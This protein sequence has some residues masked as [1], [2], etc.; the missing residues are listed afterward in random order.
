MTKNR[1][2]RA[3]SPKK[4]RPTPVRNHP[5]DA[6]LRRALLGWFRR[7]GRPLPWRGVSSPYPIWVSEVMLQQTQID[8]VIPYYHRFISR[9]PTVE[10]LAAAPL[11]RVLE[12]WSG[13]GYY[14]RARLLH[15]AAQEMVARF[16]G[17]FPDDYHAARS[18]PGVGDYT[19]RAVLSIAYHQAFAV[20]DG[21]VARVIARLQARK[22]NLHK[23][24]FRRAVEGVLKHLLPPHNPGEF[25][26]ALMQV[27]QLVCLP[28]GPRCDVCPLRRHCKSYRLGTPEHFPEPRP[29]RSAELYYLA[30]AVLR[31]RG[32]VALVRGLDQGLLGDLWNFPSA[33][34]PARYKARLALLQ[35]LRRT[36]PHA[37]VPEESSGEVSHNITHRQIHVDVYLGDIRRERAQSSPSGMKRPGDTLTVQREAAIRWV[38]LPQLERVA[39]SRLARKVAEAVSR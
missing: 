9:F 5:T 39:V 27:G 13:L 36:F 25:N 18:L 16:G 4:D 33:F 28:R 3:R 17:Q 1:P 21:N 24:S 26:Q 6:A 34:G 19:A 11:E 32:R 22:G 2:A 20:L 37:S 29:R 10:R 7:H 35:V 12:L 15:R 38:S 30:S 14:R 31:K 23:K 8:T